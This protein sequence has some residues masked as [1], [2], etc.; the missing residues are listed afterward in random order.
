MAFGWADLSGFWEFT[1]AFLDSL[2]RAGVP[3]A[4]VIAED[5]ATVAR[6]ER[7]HPGQVIHFE[8]FGASTAHDFRS[9]MYHVTVS[10][11]AVYLWRLLAL[12]FSPLWSDADIIWLTSPWPEILRSAGSCDVMVQSD[13][14]C[15]FVGEQGGWCTADLTAPET[16]AV[17]KLEH[18]REHRGS[19]SLLCTGLVF[20]QPTASV[21]SFLSDWDAALQERVARGTPGLN[22]PL[23]NEVLLRQQSDL[24]RPCYLSRV[25]FPTG[26][27]FFNETW[28][29]RHPEAPVAVHLNWVGSAAAKRKRAAELGVI[30]AGAGE[31]G[32]EADVPPR[33]APPRRLSRAGR[34]REAG[35]AMLWWALGLAALWVAAA[36]V[37]R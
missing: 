32:G 2:A 37:G 5:N 6:Y 31:D 14:A 16:G 21:L 7:T 8:L 19:N 29:A 34:A 20:A 24:L 30:L 25:R 9:N 10:R 35:A 27:L 26:Y 36:A 11:R 33:P 3:N 4:V 18:I 17:P 13:A 15:R 23:F 1:D 12:G 22:Q 28:R